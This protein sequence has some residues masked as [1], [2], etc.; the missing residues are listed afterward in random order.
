MSAVPATGDQQQ[1]LRRRW[2][3]QARSYDRQMGF[4]DRRLFGDTR[5]W[6]CRQAHGT[7]LE[8]A[9]GTGLNLDWYPDG[10]T[11]TGIDLDRKSVV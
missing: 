10:V 7:V 11:L 2:D 9:I 5:E 1:R 4:W 6:I 3:K 8:V